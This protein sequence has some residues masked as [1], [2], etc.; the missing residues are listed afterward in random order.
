MRGYRYCPARVEKKVT[1]NR[2]H[3][4]FYGTNQRAIM[5]T[6]TFIKY[7]KNKQKYGN[8][9]RYLLKLN[10][11]WQTDLEYIDF[12]FTNYILVVIKF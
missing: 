1:N 8:L 4:Y 2:F 6:K 10:K 9:T 5:S 7:K 11:K 3:I 12:V